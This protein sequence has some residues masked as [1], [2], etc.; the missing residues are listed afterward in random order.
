MF[1]FDRRFKYIIESLNFNIK[2][3]DFVY[4]KSLNT[5]GY[6][7]N[8]THDGS[9]CLLHMRPKI[10]EWKGRRTLVRPLPPFRY[11]HLKSFNREELTKIPEE[12]V[13]DLSKFN[14]NELN[15]NNINIK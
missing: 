14:V 15:T 9:Q 11:T 13:D 5:V 1:N 2:N 3:G 8:C 7:T 12:M 4:I 10:I 6:V